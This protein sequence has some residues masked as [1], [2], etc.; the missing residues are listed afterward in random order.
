MTRFHG[1]ATK[2]L[3]K[4]TGCRRCLEY[5]ASALPP[6]MMRLAICGTNSLRKHSRSVYVR[7]CLLQMELDPLG[8]R[9]HALLSNV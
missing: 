6:L 7:E 5:F 8:A 2:W 9:N 1:V 3:P 4:D